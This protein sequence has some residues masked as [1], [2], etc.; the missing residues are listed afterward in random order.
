MRDARERVARHPAGK[1]ARRS[2][3]RR[4]RETRPGRRGDIPD[5]AR[6]RSGAAAHAGAARSPPTRQSADRRRDG[7]P[8]AARVE[9][10][11]AWHRGVQAGLRRLA[12]AGGGC[13]ASA[14]ERAEASAAS[15]L[16][17]GAA[18]IVSA[19]AGASACRT[20]TARQVSKY[21]ESI[22]VKS[23]RDIRESAAPLGLGARPA[24]ALLVAWLAYRSVPIAA[25]RTAL[26]AVG[27]AVPVARLAGHL[28][29]AARRR[30]AAARP[31]AVVPILVDASR[32]MAWPMPAARGGSIAPARSSKTTC[33][34]RSS[35]RFHTDVL[36]FGERLAPVEPAALVGHRPADVARRRARGGQGSLSRTVVAGIVLVSDGGDNGTRGRRVP[37]RPPGRRCSRWASARERCRRIVRSS[38]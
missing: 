15:K 8:R 35:P 33:C 37:R 17:D 28:P 26:D 2:K 38:A 3:G 11:G 23:S 24:A 13:R 16:S 25:A 14:L 6:A 20:G 27:A 22:A 18:R 12:V 21:F 29:H 36:R 4:R 32:S 9:P 7:D 30:T 34:R 31:G 10:F 19:P 5:A 1:C